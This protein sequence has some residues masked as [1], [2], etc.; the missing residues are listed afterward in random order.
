MCYVVIK[1]PTCIF[2]FRDI[3]GSSDFSQLLDLSSGSPLVVVM[4]TTGSMGTSINA[5]KQQVREIV[6]ST[7]TGPNKPSTYVLVPYN[8]PDAGPAIR[9][10]DA[11]YFLEQGIIYLTVDHFKIDKS[12]IMIDNTLKVLLEKNKCILGPAF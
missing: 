3:F 11:D 5:L 1:F 7:K 10:E 4:D 2:F 9:T 6:N 12:K 8:D